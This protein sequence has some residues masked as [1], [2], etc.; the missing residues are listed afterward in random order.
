M[1][2]M[3]TIMLTISI[4]VFS[5][6]TVLTTLEHVNAAGEENT[7]Y[8][9][10]DGGQDYTS[11]QDAIDNASTGDKIIVYNGTFQDQLWIDK[12]IDL[13]G[14]GE[15]KIIGNNYTNAI[16]CM[17]NNSSIKNLII[18]NWDNGLY[19]SGKN[20]YVKNCF[21][22]KNNCGIYLST[23]NF[24]TVD[25]CTLK[26]NIYSGLVFHGSSNCKIRESNF[27]NNSNGII[28]ELYW[29]ISNSYDN[30]IENEQISIRY[31]QENNFILCNFCGNNVHA[32]ID[33]EV[34]LLDNNSNNSF[35]NGLVGN[36][37]DDYNGTD[38]NGDGIGDTPY[39][40]SGN[41][42]DLYPLMEPYN[43]S[44]I[45]SGEDDDMN[46]QNN[47]NDTNNSANGKRDKNKDEVI[48]GF[49]I[50]FLIAATVFFVFYKR[51]KKK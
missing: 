49:I 6:F 27:I 8:V 12:P 46:N 3:K 28:L 11:I 29:N 5:S 21:F 36:Y 10:D 39:N 16:M 48:A 15:T 34:T 31:S 42:Q 20:N 35:D 26:D 30:S 41:S 44:S 43:N 9:D 25:K 47:T 40:V 23:T 2:G 1:F 51:G 13:I 50:L 19:I 18:Q 4:I 45:P 17:S 7:I 33:P 24:I 37:W 38:E 22:Y 32:Y 14:S